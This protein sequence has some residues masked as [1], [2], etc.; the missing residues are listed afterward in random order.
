MTPVTAVS[1]S[2]ALLAPLNTREAA[3]VL[4]V[5]ER[6]VNQ[7]IDR[8]KLRVYRQRRR[9]AGKRPR[10]ILLADLLAYAVEERAATTVAFTKRGRTTLHEAL[11]EDAIQQVWRTVDAQIATLAGAADQ[12]GILAATLAQVSGRLQQLVAG[13]EIT[14]GPLR[15]AVGHMLAP[16]LPSV[17]RVAASRNAVES[18]PGI[19]GG[20]PVVSGTRIPVYMLADMRSQGVSDDV[21]LDE[22]PALTPDVLREALL[23]AELH[24][25][26][27]RPKHVDAPWRSEAPVFRVSAGARRVPAAARKAAAKRQQPAARPRTAGRPNR[28][29]S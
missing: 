2:P 23:Y 1:R 8:D 9:I 29:A 16:L 22:Y 3:F 28:F 10:T 7:A 25:R 12:P 26:A 18:D 11:A 13:V 4:D 27:G 21:L 5:N 14:V 15:L 20:E 19:R 24:P 17:A 6:Q